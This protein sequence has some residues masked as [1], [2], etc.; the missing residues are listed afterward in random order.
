M[1]TILKG[2]AC[3]AILTISIFMLTACGGRTV[4]KYETPPSVIANCPK[5]V[6][7]AEE[8]IQ[9]FGGVAQELGR[10]VPQYIKCREASLGHVK[11]GD[12]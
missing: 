10:V 12:K 6:E 5:L 9:D 1:K 11:K 7:P 2:I 8:D 3:Y 4:I